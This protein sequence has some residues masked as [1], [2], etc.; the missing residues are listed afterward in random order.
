MKIQDGGRSTV[1]RRGRASA[2]ILHGNG[3][4]EDQN[5]A[6]H[7]SKLEISTLLKVYTASLFVT[8]FPPSLRLQENGGILLA[9]QPMRDDDVY[10][11]YGRPRYALRSPGLAL[12]LAI[13]LHELAFNR[14]TRCSRHFPIA[15]F[16]LDTHVL[17]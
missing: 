4:R 10:Y 3:G 2:S 13:W 11:W 16:L 12:V 15:L 1:C 6:T 17:V 7:R 14:S 5:S 8:V 9:K